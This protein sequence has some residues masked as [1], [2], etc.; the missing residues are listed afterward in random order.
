MAVEPAP[1]Y[2]YR[3]LAPLRSKRNKPKMKIMADGC[4]GKRLGEQ[5]LLFISTLSDKSASA[6][7]L[8]LPASP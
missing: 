4:I 3:L 5:W 6:Y 2:L 8:D 1:V 7:C